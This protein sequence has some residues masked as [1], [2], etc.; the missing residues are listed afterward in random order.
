[1]SSFTYN[2]VPGN[3]APKT[4]D[5]FH[6]QRVNYLKGLLQDETNDL[7]EAIN[8]ELIML[9][10]QQE[11]IE[12]RDIIKSELLMCEENN[13][14]K[15]HVC[16]EAALLDREFYTRKHLSQDLKTKQE[17]KMAAK[18]EQAMRNGHEQKRKNW[19]NQFLAD[20]L[21][22]HREY[23]DFHRKKHVKTI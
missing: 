7:K 4:D 6:D 15:S 13:R 22:H 17:L 5:F 12:V 11:Q 19:Q 14:D 10:L 2:Q 23:F 20:L 3:L 16:L 9:E 18:C 1:M 21:N 8:K